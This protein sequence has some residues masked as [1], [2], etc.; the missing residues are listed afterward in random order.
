MGS[1]YSTMDQVNLWKK[2]FKKF[3]GVLYVIGRPHPFKILKGCLPYIILGTFLNTL[4]QMIQ[5][6]IENVLETIVLE[7]YESPF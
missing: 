7:T 2:A 6:L 3:E 1:K 4:T 5:E